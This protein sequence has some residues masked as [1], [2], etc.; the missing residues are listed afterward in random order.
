MVVEGQ[1]VPYE[2]ATTLREAR[3]ILAAT[4]PRA[5]ICDLHLPD[6]FGWDLLSEAR[7]TFG[8]GLPL[9]LVT[10]DYLAEAQARSRT[11]DLN[12]LVHVGPLR[13]P[14]LVRIVQSL[15]D[16]PPHR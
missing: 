15:L 11:A 10:A 14:T 9:A 5:I 2:T 16:S 8:E 1:D 4:E 7:R 3:R 12:A 6:G 13:I